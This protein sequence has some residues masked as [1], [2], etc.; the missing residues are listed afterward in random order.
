MCEIMSRSF[1]SATLSKQALV[2]YQK[3]R[4]ARLQQRISQERAKKG[5]DA[6]DAAF[7]DDEMDA[8]ARELEAISP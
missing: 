5:F 7:E 1:G 2:D 4:V 6:L 8:V 3:E